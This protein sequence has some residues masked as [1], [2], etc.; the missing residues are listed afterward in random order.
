MMRSRRGFTLVEIM[1]AMIM[2]LL[3]GGALT[4]ILLNTMRVS[5]AQMI[6]ADMQ[7]NVRTAGLI[8]PMELR[9]IGYDSNIYVLPPS[10]A[11]AVT[12]DIEAMGQN[13]IQF[14]AARGFGILCEY[15]AANLDAGNPVVWKFL[16]PVF[17]MRSV[18][19]NDLIKLHVENNPNASFDD[20]WARLTVQAGTVDENA[21]CGGQPAV[22]FRTV[23]G[24][25]QV[26]PL[27]GQ[28]L[29]STAVFLGSPARW[30]ER[31]RYGPFVDADG[32]TYLGLLSLSAGDNVPQPVAGPI[33]PADGV[34]F[35]YFDANMALLTPGVNPSWQV[36]NI[37]VRLIGQTRAPISKSGTSQRLAS[38]MVTV[39]RVALRNTLKP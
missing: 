38:E 15:D 26:G 12:S 21:N 34:Q 5:Q 37:E 20:Q 2:M 23:A 19:D 17:G 35:R 30:Y 10:T 13:F 29:K 25:V 39:T 31:V 8:L 4:R 14:R 32:R 27:A 24:P 11:T 7:G 3:V 9:E 22:E 16:K 33:R 6:Q 28:V 36:R 18:R 1:I